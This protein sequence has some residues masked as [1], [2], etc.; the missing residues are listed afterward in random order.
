M[1]L[2]LTVL[3]AGSWGTTMA[4]HLARNGHAVRLWARSDRLADEIRIFGEN[5]TY[6]P[7][8]TIPEAV[9]TTSDLEAAVRGTE[10]VFVA[11]PSQGVRDVARN[12]A[13]LVAP[14]ARFVSLTKGIEITTLMRMTEVI[15]DELNGDGHPVLAL[16]G[17]SLAREVVVGMPTALVAASPDEEVAKDIQTIAMSDAVRVYTNADLVGVELAAALKNVIAIAAGISDGLG[18]GD[19]TR[20]ALITRGLAEIVRVGSVL[21]GRRETFA[22]LAGLGDLITTCSS[23]HSRNHHLGTEI[24]SGRSLED[25]ESEMVMVAEGVPTTRAVKELSIRHRVDVPITNEVHAVLFEGKD[26][27]EA[28]NALML[29]RPRA[30]VW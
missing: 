1:S 18:H 10:T 26:P 29:R 13:P 23:S 20:G 2:P 8:I 21:G 28:I 15:R 16:C 30:E 4:V 17:P 12:V 14:A 27:R 25:V 24:A 6:L 19:N 7:G 11:I 3:G 22:G 5:R 9:E